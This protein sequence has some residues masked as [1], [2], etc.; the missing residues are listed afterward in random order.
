MTPV[1]ALRKP[2]II[3][4]FG[5]YVEGSVKSLVAG[6]TTTVSGCSS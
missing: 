2:N 3:R 5:G 6:D 4:D 1:L